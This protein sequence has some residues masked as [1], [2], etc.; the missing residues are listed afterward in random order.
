MLVTIG[1]GLLRLRFWWWPFHPLGYL[2]ANCW[3]MHWFWVPFFI[4]WG[5]KVLTLR[6]G[7]LRL[8]RRM[9]PLAVGLMMGDMVG[10]GIWQLGNIL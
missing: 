5:A 4:G 7:G 8:Y 2:A 10:R 3:G 1:L 6:Y 9:M